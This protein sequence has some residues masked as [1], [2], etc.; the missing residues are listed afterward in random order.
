[1]HDFDELLVVFVRAME[2][3]LL[4]KGRSISRTVTVWA[5]V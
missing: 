2:R 3:R 4:N 1:M 5:A